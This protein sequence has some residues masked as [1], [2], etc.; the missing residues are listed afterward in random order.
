MLKA[1]SAYKIAN[2]FLDAF[3]PYLEKSP[4]S[5]PELKTQPY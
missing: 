3:S 1:T 5:I 4:E 2:L